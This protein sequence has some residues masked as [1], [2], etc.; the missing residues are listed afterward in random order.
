[1]LGFV[2]T[3]AI[4]DVISTIY[5]LAIVL[6]SSYTFITVCNTNCDQLP[7]FNPGALNIRTSPISA[8]WD[9]VRREIVL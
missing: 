6:T 9:C 1:M 7:Q 5:Q 8:D 4:H 2:T 3:A